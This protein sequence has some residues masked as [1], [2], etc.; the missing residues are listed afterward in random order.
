LAI[1][2]DVEPRIDKYTAVHTRARVPSTQ[3]YAQGETHGRPA[4]IAVVI[5]CV[6][7]I[8]L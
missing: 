6:L 7:D 2:Q 5:V 1:C 3:R 8:D 4:W